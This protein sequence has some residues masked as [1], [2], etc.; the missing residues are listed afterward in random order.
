MDFTA[1]IAA[2]LQWKHFYS[3]KFMTGFNKIKNADGFQIAPFLKGFSLDLK[4]PKFQTG[5]GNSPF[6][7]S[8]IKYQRRSIVFPIYLAKRV[9]YTIRWIFF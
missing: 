2:H 8:P 6:L 5:T 7:I 3:V 9:S 1:Q 4:T